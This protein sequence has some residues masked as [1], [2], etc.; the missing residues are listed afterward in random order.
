MIARVH[1][2]AALG[3]GA[4]VSAIASRDPR[5]AVELTEHLGGRAVLYAEL[6]DGADA[7]VVC[8]PPSTHL[9]H[10]RHALDGGAAVLVEKPLATTLDDADRLVEL[11]A[12]R[13][14]LYGENLLH[15]PIVRSFLARV[16]AL[17]PLTVLELRAL[18]G[19]PDWG[20]FT[21]PDS[22][23]GALFDL[24]AHPLALALRIA[25]TAGA[26]EPVAVSAELRGGSSRVDEHAEARLRFA[27]GME[28]RVVVSW[29]AGPSPVWDIQA[30]SDTGVLRAEIMP[31][32]QLE[33]D[34]ESVPAASSPAPGPI[35]ALGFAGQIEVLLQV[36][37]S[38]R[39]E[40][41]ATVELGR[42][43][44]DVTCGAYASAARGGATVRLPYEGRRDLTPA[45]ILRS[46]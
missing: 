44:L 45:D 5:R 15:A 1:G 39:D 8:T 26:G 6:P 32:A 43:V 21:S 30:A 35:G 37:D 25:D 34:G 3:V 42:R 36:G 10:V 46:R 2:A 9:E 31:S 33:Y 18:Q 13:R 11:A 38:S 41:G 40:H 22:G 14:V 28:A 16:P 17:G 20:E 4:T 19:L 23:G 7:V 24:G 29:Q 27:S 12:G